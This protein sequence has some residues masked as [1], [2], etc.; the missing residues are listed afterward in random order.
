[1]KTSDSRVLVVPVVMKGLRPPA[2]FLASSGALAII[3]GLEGFITFRFV[4]PGQPWD[5]GSTLVR[6]PGFVS[7]LAKLIAL[8]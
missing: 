6:E 4:C 8:S 1:M 7:F 5:D 3:L 2:G